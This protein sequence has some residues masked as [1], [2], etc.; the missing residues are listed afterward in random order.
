MSLVTFGLFASLSSP[1]VGV[2][3]A[4]RLKSPEGELHHSLPTI[5]SLR[6][7]PDGRVLVSDK[8]SNGVWVADFERNRVDLVRLGDQNS[9]LF[10]ASG[11]LFDLGGDSTLMVDGASGRLT[12]LHGA[13]FVESSVKVTGL[14][15][16]VV[17]A[18][19]LGTILFAKGA[20]ETD[21]TDLLY[22][23]GPGRGLSRVTRYFTGHARHSKSVDSTRGYTIVQFR[24]AESDAIEQPAIH[25]DGWVAVARVSPLRVEWF[26]PSAGSSI[27]VPVRISG[28]GWVATSP[29]LMDLPN[30]AVFAAPDGTL[31]L[32]RVFERSDSLRYFDWVGRNGTK[33]VFAIGS[34]QRIVGFGKASVFII[35]MMPN[36]DRTL[37]RHSWPP[38]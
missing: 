14:G 5:I 30:P 8:A 6:E 2:S 32:Q 10:Q 37:V 33:S 29:F 7:L 24:L 23:G 28:P 13:A 26:P 19:T 21:S 12:V 36:G 20:N 11:R 4:V 38:I 15:G 25:S 35:S 22:V 18:D 9:A 16:A 1:N 31:L 27:T 17:G 34:N 3:Q